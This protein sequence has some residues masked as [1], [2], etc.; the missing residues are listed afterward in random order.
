MPT[1][2]LQ[3]TFYQFWL[4]HKGI[5]YTVVTI[6][7]LLQSVCTFAEFSQKTSILRWWFISQLFQTSWP[8]TARPRQQRLDAC[9]CFRGQQG[10]VPQGHRINHGNWH[11]AGRRMQTSVQHQPTLPMIQVTE[12]YETTS[13]AAHIPSWELTYIN[14]DSKPTAKTGSSSRQ[15]SQNKSSCWTA[16]KCSRAVRLTAF[17]AIR[18]HIKS[19]SLL[20]MKAS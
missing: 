12:G 13:R 16:L 11:V 17:Q 15:I 1:Q 7:R 20:H 14:L 8:S 6:R 3:Q 19:V 18:I 9:C 10:N 2:L 4:N 5:L